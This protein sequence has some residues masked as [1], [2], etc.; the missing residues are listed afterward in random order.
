MQILYAV[1]IIVEFLLLGLLIL[2][3]CIYLA[4]IVFNKKF[5]IRA[6]FKNFSQKM[7]MTLGL[8]CFFYGLYFALVLLGSYFIDSQMK[9]RLFLHIREHLTAY[10]YLGLFV[11]MSLTIF[12]YLVRMVIKHLCNS[13]CK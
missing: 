12:I 5:P 6:L 4:Q 13:R 11:F 3:F 1:G 10:I 2:Y 9:L 8:G 7:W